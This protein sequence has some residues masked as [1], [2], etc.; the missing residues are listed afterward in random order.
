MKKV[1]LVTIQSNNFGNRLQ[2]FAL[3]TILEQSGCNVINLIVNATDVSQMQKAKNI[4]RSLLVTLGMKRFI[5]GVSV[6]ER[7]NSCKFFSAS[8]IHNYLFIPRE[9]LSKYNFEQF[10]VAITGSDQVW[11]NW[12]RLKDELSYY[13]LEFINPD[14]RIAYAPS[15]G[16]KKFSEKD[17]EKHRQGLLGMKAL[18]C[19]EQ[20]GCD[21]INELTGRNAQKVFDPT[22]LL[23]AKEWEEI[24][25]K[26]KFIVPENYLLQ[27]MLGSVSNEFQKEIKKISDLRK[28]QIINVNDIY[29]SKHYGISPAEFV[30]LIH[31]ADT[32]CTD[33]FHAAVFSIIFEKNL[34]VF[35]RISPKLGNMFGRLH[36]LLQPLG[37]M[38]LVYGNEASEV[39]DFSTV[40]GE[41]EKKYIQN[42]Q[43]KSIKYLQD[44]LRCQ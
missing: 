34:R 33:S 25:E 14:K 28:I 3:Q 10:D 16:F 13:Y 35:E 9:K 15:F 5:P 26:P 6:W 2:N 41:Q 4:V 38:K 21:L 11:H 31:H 39:S 17:I 24:E 27:Y 8:H 1:L 7:I 22:L 23:T 36:D 32:I 19:R 20:E 29:D 12:N 44:S 42:E 40:L 18:S 43:K 37:L 30:W